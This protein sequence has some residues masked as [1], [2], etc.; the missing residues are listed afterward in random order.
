MGAKIGRRCFIDPGINGIFEID[1]LTVGNDSIVLT[2]N[3]HGH[4]VD[5]GT[6]QL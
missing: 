1:N 5:H 3:I 6:L 2:P 4:F